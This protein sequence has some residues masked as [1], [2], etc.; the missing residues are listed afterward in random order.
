MAT[1]AISIQLTQLHNDVDDMKLILKELTVAIN[2]LAIVEERVA[3]TGQA[4]ERAFKA[5]E[6]V[7]ERVSG[8]E[9]QAVEST[10]T[11]HLADKAIWSA[12]TAIAV[13]AAHKI[14][15]L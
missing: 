15:L 2:R 12:V 14:G 10:R 9:K 1:D 6:K 7:E 11:N 3:Q 5:L 13:F 4:L 8:L